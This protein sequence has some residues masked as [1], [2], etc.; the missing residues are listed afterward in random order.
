V[1]IYILYSDNL[2]VGIERSAGDP[3]WRWVLAA[4]SREEEEE[5]EESV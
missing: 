1:S 3:N 5:E 4:R 2:R